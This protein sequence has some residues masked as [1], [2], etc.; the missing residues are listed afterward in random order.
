[1]YA[2]LIIDENRD[3]ERMEKVF[4]DYSEALSLLYHFT[5]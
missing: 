1:M 2:S 4:T 5:F 3:V